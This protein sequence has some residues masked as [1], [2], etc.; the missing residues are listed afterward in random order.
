L[1][2]SNSTFEKG[3]EQWQVIPFRLIGHMYFNTSF[4][5]SRRDIQGPITFNLKFPISNNFVFKNQE[6]VSK[7]YQKPKGLRSDVSLSRESTWV[8]SNGTPYHAVEISQP[9]SCDV[10]GRHDANSNVI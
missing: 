2:V 4:I 8:A 6:F 1:N 3:T 9:C 5:I 7:N 10:S